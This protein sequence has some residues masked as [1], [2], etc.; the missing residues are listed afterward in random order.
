MIAIFH[1]STPLL[2][3]LQ[4]ISDE[5]SLIQLILSSLDNYQ[6]ATQVKSAELDIAFAATGGTTHWVNIDK[7]IIQFEP[8]PSRATTFGDLLIEQPQNYINL[9]TPA[10]FIP[11]VDLVYSHGQLSRKQIN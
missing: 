5:R 6:F 2:S 7:I 9:A 10:G 11:L 1:A 3:K 8:L 4:N